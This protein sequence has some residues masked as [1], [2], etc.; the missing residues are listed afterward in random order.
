M[1]TTIYSRTTQHNKDVIDARP[2]CEHAVALFAMNSGRVVVAANF[3]TLG[4]NL[5]PNNRLTLVS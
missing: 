4:E 1:V 2:L 5:F 3:K